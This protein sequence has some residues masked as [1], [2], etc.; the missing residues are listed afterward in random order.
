MTRADFGL[1]GSYNKY[2]RTPFETFY[3]G[4]DGVTG[5]YTYAT[6]TVGMRGYDNGQFT[7]LGL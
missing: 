1:L 3:F 5:G 7:P 4:G 2:L 6:E